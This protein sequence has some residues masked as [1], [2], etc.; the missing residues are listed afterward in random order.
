[1]SRLIENLEKTYKIKLTEKQKSVVLHTSGPALVLSCAG[2][3]KTTVN[4]IKCANLILE[5]GVNPSNIL[6]VT[7]SKAAALEME[8]RFMRLF[9]NLVE[10]PVKFSTIHALAYRIVNEYAIKNRIKLT[11]M[12]GVNSPVSK[13]ALIKELNLKYNRERINED[14]LDELLSAIS[15][16]KNMLLSSGSEE[17]KAFSSPIPGFKSIYNDY[18]AYKRKNN[19]VDFDDMLTLCNDALKKDVALLEK[20]RNQFQYI[21]VDEAQDT[22]KVQYEII[23][24]LA[25]PRNNLT[26]IGDDDQ[27][28]YGFRGAYPDYLLNFSVKYAGAKIF[29]LDENFRSTKSI[30]DHA[31]DFIKNNTKRYRKNISTNNPEGSPI[32]IIELNSGEDQLNYIAEILGGK[33]NKADAAVLYRNNI[34]SIPLV[35]LL[36]RKGLSFY[37]RDYDESF[38]NH[39]VTTDI[40]AYCNVALNRKDI[41]SYKRIYFKTGHY[42]SKAAI[43]YVDMHIKDKTIFE[44]LLEFYKDDVRMAASVVLLIKQFNTLKQLRPEVALDYICSALGYEEYLEKNAEKQGYSL[45]NLKNII[46]TLKLIARGNS[47]TEE[48]FSRLNELKYKLENGKF[49]KNSNVV[50]L[51]TIHSAKGLEFKEVYLLDLIDDVFPG[52]TAIKE[53]EEGNKEGLEEERRVYY[54]GVT[55]AKNKLILLG[56]K[57]RNGRFVNYSRF[58]LE[59]I[60]ILRPTAKKEAA[61]A[62]AYV[63]DLHRNTFDDKSYKSIKT[64]RKKNE[65]VIGI[66]TG[67][68]IYHRKFGEGTIVETDGL[69]SITVNFDN[70]TYGRKKLSLSVCMDSELITPI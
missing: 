32:E 26:L 29:F 36:D 43:E 22:S 38:F 11:V 15:Y 60:K 59:S 37:L 55:R 8:A 33:E 58:L 42:I 61:T 21:I 27:A 35:D 46:S 12:E 3:G 18:E 23:E 50:T 30:V 45:D 4:I 70:S 10:K 6:S 13:L 39:W 1:M 2:S 41:N 20:Y 48:F 7:F 69:D 64:L 44:S 31:G 56:T 51:S 67:T 47:S 65:S 53:F 19:L 49:N 5:H 25:Y 24:K 66:S 16:C 62:S 57:R 52:R 9:G 40:L 14:K 63:S 54:V 28:I 34:S 17:V 68:K